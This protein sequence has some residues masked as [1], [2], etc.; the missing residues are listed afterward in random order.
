MLPASPLPACPTPCFRY[1]FK[2]AVLSGTSSAASLRVCHY[3]GLTETLC[4]NGLDDDCDG[5]TDMQD[6]DC[7]GRCGWGGGS[8]LL[9]PG[10]AAT[11]GPGCYSLAWL[12]LPGQAATAWLGC[13]FHMATY[14][15][16]ECTPPLPHMEMV[17]VSVRGCSTACHAL[18]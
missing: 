16:G 2:V 5:L 10:Q 11:A 7:S 4:S 8:R 3:T 6:P 12:L 18:P 9:L 13:Y 17:V 15:G 1:Q 14:G